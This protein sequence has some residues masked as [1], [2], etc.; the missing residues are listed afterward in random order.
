[1]R[2][3]RWWTSTLILILS[4]ALEAVPAH[5]QEADSTEVREV[6][7]LDVGVL[8]GMVEEGVRVNRLTDARLRQ[9]T[10]YLEA[11]RVTE[12]V[13]SR[14]YVFVGDV[15]IVDEGDTLTADQVFYDSNSK[16]G[17]AT[18]NVRLF[19]GD[20]EV[21]APS[22]RYHVDE[23]LAEFEDGVRLVDSSAVVTSN[24]GAY[25]S[26]QKHGAFSGDVVLREGAAFMS[27]DS[28]SVF[29]ET[30][31]S[32]AHGDVFMLRYGG[33]EDDQ[34]GVDSSI[35]NYLMGEDAFNDDVAGVSRVS[36][37]PVVMQVRFDSTGT[38]ADTTVVRAME[39]EVVRL[40]SLDRL[41]GTDS[42]R[43]WQEAFAAVGDSLT[44]DRYMEADSTFSESL[45]LVG[46]PIAWFETNQITGDTIRV[47]SGDSP[48]DTLFVFG[49]AFIAQEDTT[50][51]KINQLAGRRLKGMFV[52]DSLRTLEVAPNARAIR[53]HEGENHELSQAVRVSGDRAVVEFLDDGSTD[54]RFEGG[55]EGQ[56]YGPEIVPASFELDGF[57]WYPQRRPALAD[58]V[59]VSRVEQRA[60]RA[61]AETEV[62]SDLPERER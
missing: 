7:L 26:E 43:V 47:S 41:I 14:E 18:G 3:A 17:R 34:A 23:K 50:L 40:D 2:V 33:R 49:N 61:V 56:A 55:I 45:F 32:Y 5:G 11:N 35:V 54:V 62:A 53:F 19:D 60:R 38:T 6:E 29:R 13:E 21:F 51:G 31:Q 12:Y 16:L 25:W 59:D 57:G 30:R 4:C 27:T 39:I 9:G 36:G 24:I 44:Y 58:L 20:V 46:E 10:T 52:N 1:M 28:L 48:V 8:E 37:Q 22:G 15:V 42:V